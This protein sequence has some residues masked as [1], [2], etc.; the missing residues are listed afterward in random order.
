MGISSYFKYH[1]K[2]YT[3]TCVFGKVMRVM[4]YLAIK[5]STIQKH[6]RFW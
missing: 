5:L 4:G 3:C 1:I 6:T 2:V